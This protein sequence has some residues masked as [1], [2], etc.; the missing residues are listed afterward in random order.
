MTV[1]ELELTNDGEGHFTFNLNGVT[2]K[3]VTRFNYSAQC[4]VMDLFDATEAS[5]L[6]GLMMVPNVDLLFPYQQLKKTLG[7]L[8]VIES[9][10]DEYQ[11]DFALGDTVKLIW[12][13][14]GEVLPVV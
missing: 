9:A 10:S 1:N 6:Y 13:A 11:Q 4:W 3:I 7:S 14:P 8:M 5:L 12:A 2:L